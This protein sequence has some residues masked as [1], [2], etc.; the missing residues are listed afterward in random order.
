MVDKLK[1]DY[2]TVDEY[3]A[4]HPARV[5]PFLET[6]RQIIRRE[7]P[8]AK[9][10]ISYRMPGYKFHGMLVWFAAFANHY[11]LFGFSR[12]NEVFK[13]QLTGY[14]LSK[15]TIR[16]PYDKRVPEELITEIV[17]YRVKENLAKKLAREAAKMKRMREK[18]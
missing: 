8:E 13:E 18:N 3:I 7:A 1:P 9:E 6:V 12:T 15:G 16:F 11:S 4:S 10:V 5:R 14:V 2:Q 17:R